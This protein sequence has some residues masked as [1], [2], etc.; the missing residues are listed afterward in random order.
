MEIRNKDVLN[1]IINIFHV[2]TF[3]AGFSCFALKV[4]VSIMIR[5]TTAIFFTMT[6]STAAEHSL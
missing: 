4:V 3:R 6:I 5:T 2:L 1:M